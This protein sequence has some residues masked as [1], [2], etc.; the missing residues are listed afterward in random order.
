MLLAINS[1]LTFVY[2]LCIGITI[3]AGQFIHA[4]LNNNI[5]NVLLVSPLSFSL[6]RC[7]I[8]DLRH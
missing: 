6:M 8:H 7:V 3:H 2:F 5:F 1:S 4:S